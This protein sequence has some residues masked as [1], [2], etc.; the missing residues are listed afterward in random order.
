MILSIKK[1]RIVVNINLR[2]NVKRQALLLIVVGFFYLL[3]AIL[4]F[5]LQSLI[6]GLVF[7]FMFV[8]YLVIG[9]IFLKLI[10]K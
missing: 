6:W 9:I 4:M 5:I 3:G 10:K 7:L 2:F 1:K 8:G